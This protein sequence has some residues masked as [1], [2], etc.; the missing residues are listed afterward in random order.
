[1]P[2]IARQKIYRVLDANFN[3]AKEGLRVCEDIFRFVD[4][5]P[6]LTSQYKNV[7][8]RL[9][10]AVSRLGFADVVGARDIVHDVGRGSSSTELKRSNIRDIYYANSQRAKESVRV[11][12]EFAKLVDARLAKRLKVIRYQLYEI[13][14]KVVRIL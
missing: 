8:H 9:S 7:R 1:M 12:E 13:E 11:L 4:N 6:A 2:N 14:R 10:Q 5:R 3:R